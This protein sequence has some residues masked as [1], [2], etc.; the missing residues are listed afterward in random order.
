MRKLLLAAGVGFHL[1]GLAA[2]SVAEISFYPLT[3]FGRRLSPAWMKID[4]D[5]VG[6]SDL[7]KLYDRI[8]DREEY[9]TMVLMNEIHGHI[10]PWSVLGCKMAL[11]A[12]DLLDAGPVDMT[13]V[14][15][16]GDEPPGGSVTDGISMGCSST[17]GLG[18]R[19]S[20]SRSF[21]PLACWVFSVSSTTF[22]REPV[23]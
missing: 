4:R 13:V 2:G 21:S 22:S 1:G 9:H 18:R 8:H 23:T 7:R 12:M 5:M 19:G 14:S 16:G 17:I 11:R 15:E 10:G 20:R 6:A 3:I